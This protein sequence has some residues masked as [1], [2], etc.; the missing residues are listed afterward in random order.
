M[1]KVVDIDARK[2]A[3]KI[4]N[5]APLVGPDDDLAAEGEAQTPTEYNDI[6]LSRLFA[7]QY[8]DTLRYVDQLGCWY[9]YIEAEGRWAKDEMLL[10]YTLCKKMLTRMAKKRYD[11][12][13]QA[14]L[15]SGGDKAEAKQAASK[16]ANALTSAAKVHAVID[17][18]R[19]ELVI[20]LEMFDRDNWVLN[21]PDGVFDLQSGAKRSAK[22]DDYFTKVTKVGPQEMPT[23]LWDRF[24]REIMGALVP[25]TTC[26]CAACAKSAE[27]KPEERQKL[28]DAEVTKLVTYMEEID[29]YCLTGDVKQHM[30]ILE[31]GEGGNGKGVRNDLLSQDILGLTP[32][33]YACEIPVEALLTSRNDRHPTD[34]MGLFRSR[35]AL[36]RE[37]EDRNWNEG[38]V[39]RLSGGDPVTARKMRQ[40]FVTFEAT[41]KFVIFGQH[42]P[43]LSGSDEQA[44]KRRMHLIPFPQKWD[45]PA[46]SANN[47]LLADLNLQTKLAA[48]APGILHKLIAAGVKR[49][50]RGGGI[51]R[52]ATVCMASET[53]LAD[54]DDLGTWVQANFIVKEDGFVSTDN[55]FE[56]WST[57]CK[58]RK[59]R[60][61]RSG[62]FPDQVVK[63]F[64]NP[65]VRRER[66]ARGLLGR[67][68]RGISWIPLPEG[69]EVGSAQEAMREEARKKAEE[70][71]KKAEAQ[72]KGT[73]E[74]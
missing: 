51:K 7:D 46:D 34:L 41:H 28:H 52:P 45:I 57:Y 62:E 20:T 25:V 71:R 50:K 67:G 6:N 66:L 49:F 26:A 21:T 35:L 15:I 22:R 33:G 65:K 58:E 18:A 53:Y 9:E 4:L 8:K 12:I 29:A 36:A 74:N 24:S 17:L 42:K 54:E 61:G 40:D 5:E 55:A 68:I 1:A 13:Y 32:V 72:K 48:E 16:G 59:L 64:G 56:R 2:Q 38:L 30:L 44:W 37:S 39:K 23:P 70:A 73:A 27:R 69:P 47:V 63:R 43:A 14:V 60:T 10:V 31:I 11:E 3:E 19:N